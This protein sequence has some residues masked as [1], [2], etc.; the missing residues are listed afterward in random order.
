[1]PAR[2]EEP[3]PWRSMS[4]HGVYQEINQS[5]IDALDLH[6]GDLV[7]DL[8][9]G[10]G[11]ISQILLDRHGDRLRIWAIDP[12]R[13]MLSDARTLLGGRVGTCA[14]TAEEFGEL[15]PPGSCSAVVMANTLHLVADRHAVYD[16]VRRVLAPGGVFAFNSTFYLSDDLR[17]STAYAMALGFEA[18]SLARR[19]GMTLPPFSQKNPDAQ[20][21]KMLPPVD[22]LADEL[23]SV[24]FDVV[25][26][27]ERPWVLDTGFLSS[28]MTAPYQ[29]ATVLPG[30][31]LA[32]AVDLIREASEKVAAKRPDPVPRPWLTVVGRRS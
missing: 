12:D 30:L 20:L 27:E 31:D 29:A 23:R 4:Q 11:A 26:A 18:R 2:T 24:S 8:G 15:F 7:V 22:Q 6:D 17:P 3:A 16:N 14:A 25:R 9:C 13:E 21:A 10:D 28:F 1:M 5:L 19:R 32:V